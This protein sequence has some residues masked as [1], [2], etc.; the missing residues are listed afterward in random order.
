MFQGKED[1]SLD[2]IFKE[3]GSKNMVTYLRNQAACF[4]EIKDRCN[5]P[6]TSTVQG[7]RQKVCS[8]EERTDSRTR[9]HAC[10]R[11]QGGQISGNQIA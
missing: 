2:N 5:I 8:M 9:Q 11:N 3:P 7:T 4:R 6:G 10:F 1:I